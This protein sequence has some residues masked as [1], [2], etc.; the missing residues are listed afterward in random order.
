[1]AV[2]ISE[3]AIHM[4]IGPEATPP[5]A[6]SP[7]AETVAGLTAAQHEAIVKACVEQVM[8]SLRESQAR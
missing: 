6:G 3:I 4:M 1:M 7:E 5:P 2:E 8:K